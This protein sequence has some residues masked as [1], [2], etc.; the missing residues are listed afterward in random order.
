MAKNGFKIN[1]LAAIS[2]GMVCLNA[3]IQPEES[4]K[5]LEMTTKIGQGEASGADKGRKSIGD[6]ICRS[7]PFIWV[8]LLVR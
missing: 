7:N 1:M 6:L 3:L 5:K 2:R 8:R 4:Q